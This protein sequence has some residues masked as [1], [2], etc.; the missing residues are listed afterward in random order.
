MMKTNL[1]L[2]KGKRSEGGRN[3]QLGMNIHTPLYMKQITNKDLLRSTGNSNQY[4]VITYM[5]KETE[6]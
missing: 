5:K 4:S 2:L 1:W 6:N 3:Q